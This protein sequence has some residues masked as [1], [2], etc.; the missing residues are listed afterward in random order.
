ML[1]TLATYS[2]FGIGVRTTQYDPLKEIVLYLV[3]LTEACKTALLLGT[4]L[5]DALEGPF[6]MR[7]GTIEKLGRPLPE[8]AKSSVVQGLHRPVNS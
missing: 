5:W 4:P 6:P 2:T 8:I 1:S 3:F 7:W